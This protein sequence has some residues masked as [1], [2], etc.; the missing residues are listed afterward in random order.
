MKT[1]STEPRYPLSFR[2]ARPFFTVTEPTDTPPLVP[3]DLQTLYAFGTEYTGKGVTVALIEAYDAPALREDAARFNERFCLPQTDLTLLYASGTR[4]RTVVRSWA[5]EAAADCEWAHAAAPDARILCV[6]ARDNR[7]DSLFE[8]IDAAAEAGADVISMSFGLA[9][10]AAEAAYDERMKRT[11]CI[12]TASSGDVGGEVFFPSAG[13]AV[14]SVGG[15]Q[16]FR[17]RSGEVCGRRAWEN[18]GGGESAY[19][20]KPVWQRLM[21]GCEGEKRVTPDV[22]FDAAGEPGYAVFSTACAESARAGGWV[23]AGGTSMAAPIAAGL[24]ARL[25][26]KKP[27][28]LHHGRAAHYLYT[29]AGGAEYRRPQFY[30]EEVT[31]GHSGRNEAHGGYNACTGL[32]I[33]NVRQILGSVPLHPYRAASGAGKRFTFF[34][35]R[36]KK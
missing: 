3:D 24:C 29:L 13:A 20:E 33:P 18:S 9:E 32:G 31:V 1:V 36:E 16:V 15:A 8:A 21:P 26:E 7:I 12:F 34:L 17:G 2:T 35:A 10:F 6:F 23:R 25:A 30:F 22:A 19:I 4:G 28:A 11:G 14:L 5:A 27:I